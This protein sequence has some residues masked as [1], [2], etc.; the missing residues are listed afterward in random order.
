MSKLYKL[1]KT[2]QWTNKIIRLW[3]PCVPLLSAFGEANSHF[4]QMTD[5]AHVIPFGSHLGPFY[6][7]ETH[8]VSKRLVLLA[9]VSWSKWDGYSITPTFSQ[10]TDCRRN[11]IENTGL[12]GSLWG[13]GGLSS[14][15]EIGRFSGTFSC[16]LISALFQQHMVFGDAALMCMVL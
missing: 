14:W 1:W 6:W 10:S 3:V 12:D 2:N 15:T 13:W 8:L 16:F 7:W 9:Q 5:Q 4:R 11:I